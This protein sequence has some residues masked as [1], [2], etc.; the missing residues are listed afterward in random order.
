MNRSACRRSVTCL[1]LTIMLMVCRAAT[2]Q[3]AL[4]TAR[5][6]YRAAAYDDALN[7]LNG[8]RG[9]DGRPDEGQ[10]IEEY[11]AWCLIALGRTA[12]AEQAIEAVVT[13]AP[14]YHPSDAETSPRVRSVFA[15]VRR[16]MLPGIVERTYAEAK[17]AFDRKDS[18]SAA[19]GF[20]QVIGL[21]ADSDV[22]AAASHP[23]LSDLRTLALGFRDLSATAAAPPPVA[24]SPQ[25][26][27]PRLAAPT[28]PPIVQDR[29]YGPEDTKVVPPVVLR[30]PL[31]PVGDVFALR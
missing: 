12:E 26:P 24:P 31:P 8:L 27:P 5:D 11:R 1:V 6:L 25:P 10:A 20:T 21:L 30:Q 17:A 22:A 15:D 13:A 9:P 3:D 23:P 29:I 7:V 4:A 28:P 18:A 2:A 16:R 19:A 14:S